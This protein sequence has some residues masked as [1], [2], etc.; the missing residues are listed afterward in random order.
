[1]IIINVENESFNEFDQEIS[2]KGSPGYQSGGT[3]PGQSGG[4][5]QPGGEC[6]APLG[7]LPLGDGDGCEAL[8]SRSYRCNMMLI[9]MKIMIF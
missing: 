9:M 6:F 4:H 8:S 1:M 7:A 3:P 2:V 5:R